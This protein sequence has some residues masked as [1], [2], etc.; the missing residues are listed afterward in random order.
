MLKEITTYD[1]APGLGFSPATMSRRLCKCKMLKKA[2]F[3]CITKKADRMGSCRNY[4]I[5]SSRSRHAKTPGIIVP[6]QNRYFITSFLSGIE[7]NPSKDG[8]ILII[9]HSFD[10]KVLEIR[11]ANTRYNRQVECLLI[12]LNISESKPVVQDPINA[13]IY[14]LTFNPKDRPDGVFCANEMAAVHCKTHF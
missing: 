13:A 7:N 11:Y 9:S 12:L 10:Q 1:L 14:I 3:Q 8:F 6:S 2:S 4:L 5:S